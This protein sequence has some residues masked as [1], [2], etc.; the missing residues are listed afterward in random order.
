VN[1]RTLSL[2]LL[3]TATLVTSA[4]AE[5]GGRRP[6]RQIV[7]QLGLTASQSEQIMP[8]MKTYRDSRRARIDGLTTQIRAILTPAQRERYDAL[9]S[10]HEQQ[11]S[12]SSGG[13]LSKRHG[14]AEMATSLR[15]SP[16]QINQ[17]RTLAEASMQQARADHE[18]FME[19]VKRVLTP[20]QVNQLQAMI[21]SRRS[22]DSD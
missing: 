3:L 11:R 9:K 18:R 1:I 10:E 4:A 17:V 22:T 8:L 20:D 2:I 13:A 12:A 19:S 5:P 14:L 16:E 15:L 21:R 7:D 6:W